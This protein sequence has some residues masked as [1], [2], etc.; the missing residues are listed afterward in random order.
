MENSREAPQL[1]ASR[2]E[3]GSGRSTDRQGASRFRRDGPD[4]GPQPVLA[5]ASFFEL[6]L[7]SVEMEAT[8][9]SKGSMNPARFP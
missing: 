4:R 9:R 7:A 1:P 5:A 6:S 2:V 3:S 8:P